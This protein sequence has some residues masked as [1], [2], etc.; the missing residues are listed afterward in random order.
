MKISKLT[1]EKL[2]N[3]LDLRLFED[4]CSGYTTGTALLI[5]GAAMTSPDTPIKIQEKGNTIT[6]NGYL[7]ALI[8]SII[9]ETLKLKYFTVNSRDYTIVY[10][11]FIET[12]E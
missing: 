1:L 6:Q 4:R 2:A 7:V 9:N 11:P 8:L 3:G 10:S 12:K 5:I